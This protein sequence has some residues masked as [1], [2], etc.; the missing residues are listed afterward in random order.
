LIQNN[1]IMLGVPT[2]WQAFILAILIIVG[3]AITSIKALR[4]SYSSKV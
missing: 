1:L 2:H 4:A 3:T